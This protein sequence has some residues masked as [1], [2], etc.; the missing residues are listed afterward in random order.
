VRLAD[1]DVK[2]RS[3]PGRGTLVAFRLPLVPGGAVALAA[4]R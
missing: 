2:V 4:A 1:G 3:V